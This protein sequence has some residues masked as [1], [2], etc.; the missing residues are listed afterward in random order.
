[1]E[2]GIV[3]EEYHGLHPE[4]P[5][6]EVRKIAWYHVQARHPAVRVKAHTCEGEPVVY[7]LCAAAG[8]MHIRQT[9]REGDQTVIVETAWVR[10]S[11]AFE[12]WAAILQGEA[13]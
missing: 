10:A 3:M 11:E 2:V 6:K 8:L 13:R 12:M 4:P 9:R 5:K 7:E 1:M